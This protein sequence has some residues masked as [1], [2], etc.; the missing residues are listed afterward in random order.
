MNILIATPYLPWPL[1]IGGKVA[2]FSTLEC[3]SKDHSYT[4]VCPIYSEKEAEGIGEIERRLPNVRV[5]AVP[6][7]YGEARLHASLQT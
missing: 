1:D 7:L 6:N 3:L 4:I 2:Q 5:K